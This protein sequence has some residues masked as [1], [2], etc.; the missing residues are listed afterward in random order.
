ML[1]GNLGTSTFNDDV[2]TTDTATIRGNVDTPQV[3]IGVD[4][5][6]LA[7]SPAATKCSEHTNEP[8]VVLHHTQ[9]VTVDENHVDRLRC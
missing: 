9:Y 3:V 1:V 6:E 2:W 7:Y 4:G 8:L 5:D